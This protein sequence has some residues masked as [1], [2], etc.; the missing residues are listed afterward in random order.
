MT[1]TVLSEYIEYQRTAAEIA[2]SVTP[3]NYYYPTGNVIRYG[4]TGDGVTDDTTALQNA[5]NVAQQVYILTGTLLTVYLPP[6]KY[7]HTGLTV[8]SFGVRILG[9]GATLVRNADVSALNVLMS[10][11]QIQSISAIS[12]QTIDLSSPISAGTTPVSRLTVSNASV[13]TAGDYV[14]VVSDDHISSTPGLSNE[15]EGEYARVSSVDTVHNYL[16]LYNVLEFPNVYV[17]APRVALM[18]WRPQFIIEGVNFDIASTFVST[19][20]KTELLIRGAYKPLIRDV[21]VIRSTFQ[22]VAFEG[23]L[24]AT[25]FNVFVQNI[26]QTVA[27]SNYALSEF[28]SENSSHY[29]LR[30]TKVRHMTTTGIISTSAGSSQIQRFGRTKYMQIH[31]GEAWNCWKEGVDTHGDAYKCSY[32][33]ILVRDAYVGPMGDRI[34][35]N[36]EGIGN[37]L[38]NCGSIGGTGYIFNSNFETVDS[39]RDNSAVNCWHEFKSADTFENLAFAS[40][41]ENT[42]CTGNQVINPIVYMN[43]YQGIP[44]LV[45]AFNN[46]DVINPIVYMNTATSNSSVFKVQDDATM[47]V[48]GGVIHLMSTTNNNLALLD[49]DN[50]TLTID[51]IDITGGTLR[52]I[53]DLGTTNTNFRL[54]RSFADTTP[55]TNF[56]LTT[57]GT[58]WFEL[59]RN[60]ARRGNPIQDSRTIASGVITA[61]SP[62]TVLDTEGGAGTDDLD[63][64]NGGE[65]GITVALR[66]IT[67]ARVPTIKNNTGNIK[68]GSDFPLNSTSDIIQLI[69]RS[70]IWYRQFSA[71]NG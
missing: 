11:T 57:T 40:V 54:T 38:Y 19:S 17:T 12:T 53:A 62:N 39:C 31:G 25:T 42:L 20:S 15:R 18:N 10:F 65:E 24:R 55:T 70:G 26:D 22:A 60:A 52:C 50:S 33:D 36:I 66:C 8:T 58:V 49:G 67:G 3:T 68:C 44:F 23:V 45:D 4:A 51:N 29:N 59:Y 5:L 56:L 71:D 43:T 16:Y 14:K 64:I 2:A 1:T 46:L 34:N 32:Y 35:Y 37:R 61:R 21:T 27:V 41:G 30:A 13:Y 63:T 48:Y 6:G 9:Y 28:S 7:V 47:N 69:N